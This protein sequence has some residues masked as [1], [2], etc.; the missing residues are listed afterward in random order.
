MKMGAKFGGSQCHSIS[1]RQEMPCIAGAMS[2]SWDKTGMSFLSAPPPGAH[3]A[4]TLISDFYNA[5]KKPTA[6]KNSFCD[7]LLLKS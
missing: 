7:K 2:R 1:T 4:H 6:L 5:K 3:P